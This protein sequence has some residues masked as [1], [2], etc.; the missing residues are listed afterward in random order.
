MSTSRAEQPT[1]AAV[2]VKIT[3]DA[4]SVEL[5][6]GRTVTVPIGWYPR[7]AHGSAHE[8][9]NWRLI[10]T[11]EGIHWP[12]LDEDVSVEGILFGRPSAESQASFERWLS[13]R[14]PG[15]GKRIQ[16]ARAR[17]ARSTARRRSRG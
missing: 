2:A 11:G 10:G 14:K 8:R 13:S 17:S 1:P 5:D 15:A 16:P 6:D 7:L 4:F 3:G 9:R 12:D